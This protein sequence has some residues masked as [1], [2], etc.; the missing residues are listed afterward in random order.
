MLDKLAAGGPVDDEVAAGDNV[1]IEGHDREKEGGE[2]DA[3]RAC[4]RNEEYG[5]FTLAGQG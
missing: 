1:G 3:E 5:E 4:N 2:D